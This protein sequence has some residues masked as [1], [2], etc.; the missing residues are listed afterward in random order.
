MIFYYV[1]VNGKYIGAFDKQSVENGYVPD[2]AIEI[3]NPPEHAAD[4]RRQDG[5]WDT[6]GR[7]SPAPTLD[8]KVNALMSAHFG[9]NAP[10]AAIVSKQVAHN[11]AI[12]AAEEANAAL[13]QKPP[14]DEQPTQPM[15][16]G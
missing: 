1:D 2:G 7:I 16:G 8:E 13:E 5:T 14:I 10:I 9:D 11:D 15:E 4:I 6:S 12:Q 3:Q